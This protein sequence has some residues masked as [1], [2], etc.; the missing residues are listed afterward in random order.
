MFNCNLLQCVFQ[1]SLDVPLNRFLIFTMY[2][3]IFVSNILYVILTKSEEFE[4]PTETQFKFSYVLL[5][6]YVISML[7]N[8]VQTM[9]ILRSLKTYIK[10]WRVFDLV[11][12]SFL[13]LALFF[14]LV[15][16]LWY[17]FQEIVNCVS[18]KVLPLGP[19]FDNDTN[20]LQDCTVVSHIAKDCTSLCEVRKNLVDLESVFL[21]LGATQALMRLSYWMQLQ[22]K[23]GPVVINISKVVTDILTVAGAYVLVMFSFSSGLV[24]VLTN[25]NYQQK[26]STD[27]DTIGQYANNFG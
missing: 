3:L 27:T 6:V 9:S 16:T 24:F 2:Y 18:T 12:H 25:E 5:T 8:D 13:L 4:H 14:K 23:L 19:H 15:R 17:P 22:E 21:S 10:F 11:L 20:I 7:W 1:M 26:N